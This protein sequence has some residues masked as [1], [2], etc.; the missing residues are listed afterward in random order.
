MRDLVDY[1]CYFTLGATLPFG[2]IP[3]SSN[4]FD[5][6]PDELVFRIW[7]LFEP[8]ELGRLSQVCKRFKR[9]SYDIPLWQDIA[10]RNNWGLLES[11]SLICRIRSFR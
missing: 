7:K 11:I 1:F 6:L 3:E 4:N 5:Y 8:S 9:L 2:S 10:V